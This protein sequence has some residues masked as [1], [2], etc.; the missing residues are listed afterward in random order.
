MAAYDYARLREQLPMLAT[1]VWPADRLALIVDAHEKGDSFSQMAR[2]IGGGATKCACISQGR[3][4]GLPLRDRNGCYLKHVQAR[5]PAPAQQVRKKA[6]KAPP[7][8]PKAPKPPRDAEI[9]EALA[10]PGL[11]PVLISQLSANQCRWPVDDPQDPDFAFCGRLK[12]EAGPYCAAH[13]KAAVDHAAT[14]K[15]RRSK[16]ERHARL[17]TPR[18]KIARSA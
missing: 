7:R 18:R 6:P 12:A 9:R 11:S 15:A 17:V 1:E 4:I 3:R 2:R 8:P 10:L 5:S 14:A 13:H 16:P